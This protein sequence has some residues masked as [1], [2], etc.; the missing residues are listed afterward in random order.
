MQSC[1]KPMPQR[2]FTMIELLVVL[3]VIAIGA[4]A[5][6][7]ALRDPAATRLEREASR[8]VALLDAARTE[9]RAS[10]VAVTWAPIARDPSIPE[11][12][13]FRFNGLPPSSDMPTQWLEPTVTAEVSG[14]KEL[15]LGPEPVIGPQRLI[16]RLDKQALT[17]QTDG[18]SVFAVVDT[19][20]PLTLDARTS[21]S[22][23]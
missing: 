17:I 11:H 14:A 9:S 18:L 20:S 2:G 10:G 7:L 12:I 16:L 6:S 3:A 21:R 8:L 4:S 23:Q 19:D 1:D 5:V 15:I 22:P 13:D